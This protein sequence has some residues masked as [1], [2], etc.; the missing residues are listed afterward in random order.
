MTER[1]ELLQ[2][3]ATLEAQRG[4]LGD[5]VVDTS[6]AA[7]Q[8]KLAALSPPSDQQRKQATVLF[9]DLSGFTAMSDAM[10]AE[11]VGE[12]MNA[13]W[14]DLDQEITTHGGHI[15]KHMG[16]AVMVIWGAEAAREDDP[17]RAIRA[18]L[19]MREALHDFNRSQT[20]IAPL[21]MRIGV[22]TGPVLLGEMGTTGEYTAIGD[23]V[24]VAS[25][26]EEAAPVG[27]ILISHA[28]YSH[29]RGLFDVQPL[30]PVQVKGKAEPI[31]VYLVEQAKPRAFHLGTRGVEGVETPM[32]GREGPLR[33]LQEALRAAMAEG[34]H[35]V[36]TIAGEAGLGKSRLIY[37]FENWVE[38]LPEL[39]R[40]FKG[41]AG[42]ETQSRPYALIRDLFSFRFQIQDSDPAQLVRQKMED[43]MVEALGGGAAE[44]T[45]PDPGL[46]YRV[47]AHFIGQL[48]GFDFH[49][50]AYLQGVLGD[51]KQLRDRALLY[52]GDFFKATAA[53]RPTLILLE[54][55]HWADNSSLDALNHLA[56]AMPGQRLLIVAST[57]PTLFERRPDWGAGQPFHVRL[58]L[59]P[60]SKED[61]RRLV[62]EILRK[63]DPVPAALR[64]LVVG[65]AEG[66]PFYVE[67]L[68]KMLIEEGVIVTG[69]E[70]WR[71]DPG[72]LTT[73]RVP[74][75]LT[76]ILQARLDGLPAEE[77]TALQRAAVVG[78]TFWDDTVA[79]LGECAE[80]ATE[81]LPPGCTVQVPIQRALSS[82]CGK[83]MIF[84]QESPAFAGTEEYVFKHAILRAVTY[85]RV[86]RRER[87]VYH[88]R[89]A[90]WLME[91]S[92][93]RAG[94]YTALIADHLELA[95][96]TGQA[97]AYLRKAG[98]QAAAQFANREAVAFFGRA[99]GLIEA[100]DPAAWAEERYALLM[101]RERVYDVQGDR[102]RQQEGLAS[103]QALL[104]AAWAAAPAGDL[105]GRGRIQI[106]QAEVALR[107]AHY[108]ETVGDYVRA[109]EAAREAIALSGRG[110]A[111]LREAAEEAARAAGEVP[112]PPG[113]RSEIL[114]LQSVG[115]LHWG[116]GLWRQGNYEQAQRRLERALDL[117]RQGGLRQVEADSLRNLGNVCWY[118]GDYGG[119]R[120]SYRQALEI[121]RQIGD[122]QGEST[123]LSNLG[124]V[125]AE[126]GDYQEA[127]SYY[128]QALQI[129][130]EI[131][132]RRG[133]GIVLNNLG[134]VADNQGE[135]TEAGTYYAQAL[136]IFGQIGDRRGEGLVLYNLGPLDHYQGDYSAAQ[137][138][139]EQALQVFRQVG[140]RKGEGLV[141][142]NLGLLY[143]HRG[144]DSAGRAYSEQA[145][146]IAQQIGDPVSQAHALIH[147]GHNQLA[148]GRLEEAA[149]AY[150]QAREIRQELDQPS[151]AV[152]CQAGLA[153]V[154]LARG[155]VD[156]AQAHVEE[157]LSYLQEHRLEGVEEPF[158]VYLTCLELLWATDDARG[159]ALLDRAYRQLQD[160]AAKIADE[161]K[162]RTFLQEMPAHREIV[163]AWE[164][165]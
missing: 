162:R 33:Q 71:V 23:A 85:E 20:E 76:G 152:E 32:V 49:D 25:R 53:R 147:L 139:Y 96:R 138:H 120:H 12:T 8:D 58:N 13:L 38:L 157:I 61:C 82:L 43:G 107:R 99:L 117:A 56:L 94:E 72:R 84:R 141:L 113:A 133:E 37:E 121:H 164:T 159:G 29:V 40:F 35:Q 127:A 9:A 144:E 104:A 66:N 18:A 89:V 134:L 151:M 81:A 146:Q 68:I 70:R 161:D 74:P 112:A 100:D 19:A 24:N 98:E 142:S 31:Q 79:F 57:R 78:R 129:C 154:A 65:G 73:A 108:G 11:V 50:S 124:L 64:E 87:R 126:Q 45:P 54:D 153:R 158:R 83:E 75:T 28:T 97:I 42:L 148:L 116:R 3:V 119:V 136:Q 125:A 155:D 123:T 7:L 48:I 132:H 140:D 5:A 149:A 44:E 26:L 106:R 21:Q 67:E 47:W 160:R 34:A 10:D 41:R 39:I 2:A 91:R 15:D 156:Q 145:W 115:H 60:L 135:W 90:T 17:E 4:L 6:I 16:D 69:A 30:E 80:E 137:A 52:M 59:P 14:G 27:G 63:V 114:S 101:A 22:N 103:L 122:R 130:R 95:G 51:A 131:G 88:A 62:Q 109:I 165:R 111:L 163:R 1:E 55:I 77:R 46:P 36:V 110:E 128:G 102:E 118:L 92:G 150:R 86:L 143:H 105:A 93:E